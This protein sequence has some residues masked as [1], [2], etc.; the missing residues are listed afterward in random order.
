MK[1]FATNPTLATAMLRE[2][3]GGKNDVS[4]LEAQTEGIGFD[5]SKESGHPRHEQ[6]FPRHPR[7]VH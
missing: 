1:G 2:Q 6:H 5:K 7:Q 3:L 4:F